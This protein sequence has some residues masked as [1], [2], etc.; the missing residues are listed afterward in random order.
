MKYMSLKWH[1]ASTLFNRP[2][3]QTQICV[4]LNLAHSGGHGH[5]GMPEISWTLPWKSATWRAPEFFS[6]SELTGYALTL[7][8]TL[9]PSDF[10][11]TSHDCTWIKLPLALVELIYKKLTCLICYVKHIKWGVCCQLLWLKWQD[12]THKMVVNWL[13]AVVWTYYDNSSY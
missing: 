13:F 4:Q 10:R 5:C 9:R 2:F 1:C 7:P 12:L 11:V 8:F 6:V 3:F